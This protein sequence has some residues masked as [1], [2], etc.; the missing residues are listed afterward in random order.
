MSSHG[1]PVA[2]EKLTGDD[3][4]APTHAERART[5]C[6]AKATGALAT[7]TDDGYPYGSYVTFA[8]EGS[9]PVFLVS[10]LA[11][12]TQNLEKDAR[13][14][15]LVHEDGAPDPL[16]NARATLVG[17]CTRLT[18]SAGAKDAFLARHP[19][20]AYYADFN[21]FGFYRLAVESV[22][23]IG[24]YGRMS[25]VEADAWRQADVD[26]LYPAAPGI[27][28]HMNDDH[29]DAL[30]AYAR[31]F[32]RAT[33]AEEAT[34]TAIDRYGFEMSVATAAGR[35][36]ARIAFPAPLGA[37]GEARKALVDLLGVARAKLG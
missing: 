9:D 16:A 12:H 17:R 3:V 26:P 18:D 37:A 21:D 36:P 19:G 29:A 20:A 2:E 23:Y 6:A 5:L 28:A 24:G 30:V 7:L 33:A 25:W 14:S 22:R 35:R 4:R 10:T 32:T 8:L 34:M 1:R 27:L 31:A 13:A 15:L 11:A